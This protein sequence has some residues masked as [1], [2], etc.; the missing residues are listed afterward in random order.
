MLIKK[1]YQITN[2]MKAKRLTKSEE[3]ILEQLCRNARAPFRRMGRS[4][5]KSEQ[6][7]SYTVN[8]LMKRG[9][10]RGF[11]SLI[12]YSRLSALSFR[13]FFG[14]KKIS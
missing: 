6:S 1:T 11:Y 12:D 10:I 8:S 13:V 14:R 4:I 5:R 3:K 9:V 7:V 2:T